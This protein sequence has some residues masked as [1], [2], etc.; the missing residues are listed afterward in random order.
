MLSALKQKARRIGRSLERALRMLQTRAARPDRTELIAEA[1][2]VRAMTPGP[3]DDSVPLL[4]EDRD[5]R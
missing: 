4:R 1:D 2:R 3:L 5:S